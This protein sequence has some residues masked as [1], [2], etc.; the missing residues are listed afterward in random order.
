[1][2][3][4]LTIG[5]LL[6]ALFAGLFFV[7]M[8]RAFWARF[9]RLETAEDEVHRVVCDDGWETRLYRYRGSADP[10]FQSN[11]VIVSHGFCANR[12]NVDF[13]ARASLARYLNR[14]GF[15]TWVIELRGCADA[16]RTPPRGRK[17][18]EVLFE[19][20]VD[21]D[22]PAAIRHV[23]ERTGASGVHWVGHSMGGMIALAFAQGPGRSLLKS[24]T[25][26]G[27][28]ARLQMPPFV[29]FLCT[30]SWA[31]GWMSE[32]P[33]RIPCQ[34]LAPF[35]FRLPIDPMAIRQANLAPDSVRR[36]MVNVLSDMPMALTRQ[37]A[38][39]QT[40]GGDVVAAEDDRNFTAGLG[41]IEAPLLCIA[42]ADDHV[43]PPR[44]ARIAV[45]R[46]V[47]E[48]KAWMV[49][50]GDGSDAP[51]YGHGDLLIGDA[52]YQDVFPHVA[53]W[54]ADLS[55]VALE[56]EAL[57]AVARADLVVERAAVRSIP[58]VPPPP[59]AVRSVIPAPPQLRRSAPSEQPDL[60]AQ[61]EAVALGE[62]L[63]AYLAMADEVAHEGGEELGGGAPVAESEVD[64]GVGAAA[65]VAAGQDAS[66][67]VDV[68]PT[69]SE[70]VSD[71]VDAKSPPAEAVENDEH[72]AGKIEQQAARLAEVDRRARDR[73]E[74]QLPVGAE[75]RQGERRRPLRRTPPPGWETTRTDQ[76]RRQRPE[77]LHRSPVS[78]DALTEALRLSEARADRLLS[79]D[80]ARAT[81]TKSASDD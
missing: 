45:E 34:I 79:K 50:G 44:S 51:Q 3:A 6:L 63:D 32:L 9:Y 72:L 18:G 1:V 61:D 60:P 78:G 55:G 30:L 81:V 5:Y 67:E 27:S 73:R 37:M 40:S 14:L 25:A 62:G 17:K 53:A 49:L 38:R 69:V 54:V 11:P 77:R 36:A 8:H 70:E 43:A 39:W 20:F 23:L 42:G 22:M 65:D 48:R 15:D 19:D 29:H 16:T 31:L 33:L 26:I 10:E 76:T 7:V 68:A 13:H 58:W 35:Y 56:E 80:V 57:D 64:D 21:L 74:R 28:P 4:L 47:S 75:R 71:D 41:R 12:F 24:I 52:A 66:G 59:S 46:A 2:E